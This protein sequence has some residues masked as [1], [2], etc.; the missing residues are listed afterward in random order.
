MGSPRI[1]LLCGGPFAF[2]S[3]TLLA[4][5][6]YLA[7]IAIG[8]RD[9]QTISL[10]ASECERLKM[11][12]EEIGSASEMNLLAEWLDNVNPD[13]VFCICFPH[14][15]PAELLNK[16][17][18]RFINFHT[19]PLPSYRGPMPIFEV[20]RRGEKKSAVSVHLMNEE[21]DTGAVIY[22]ES[23]P[24]SPGE[25]FTSLAIKLAERTSIT[26][27]N[28]AQMLEFGT[29]IPRSVQDEDEAHFYPFPKEK[30]ITIDWN[31][32]QAESI[33]SLV[34]ASW[35][36][37]KGAITRMDGNEIRISVIH[38]LPLKNSSG[39]APGTILKIT[40]EGIVEVACINGQ[41]V[42]VFSFG[43][44]DASQQRSFIDSAGLATG[45]ILG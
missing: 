44:P 19:G 40:D 33:I 15:I 38:Q 34:N 3:I 1:A 11:P 36:W 26:S 35:P 5:E 10:L 23:V 14:R 25:T 22:E 20:I 16:K 30:D 31:T 17:P 43:Q 12:F 41:S 9:I 6:K 27:L 2:Q 42:E 21:F 13:Y 18:E 24:L 28:V 29:R 45:K 37:S 4:L 32:M 7:G 39:A 8:S